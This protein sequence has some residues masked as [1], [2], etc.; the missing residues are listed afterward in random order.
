MT[1]AVE[2]AVK[3]C[4]SET[5]AGKEDADAG[6][7]DGADL[8]GAVQESGKARIFVILPGFFDFTGGFGLK[9][10]SG[11]CLFW[12]RTGVLYSECILNS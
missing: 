2:L 9:V 1:R 5:G 7:E 8:T 10:L 3:R 4:H 11:I 6:V 12:L